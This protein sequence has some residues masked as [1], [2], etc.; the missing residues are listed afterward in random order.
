MLATKLY[1]INQQLF[2]SWTHKV[3]KL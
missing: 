2:V 1:L 3:A